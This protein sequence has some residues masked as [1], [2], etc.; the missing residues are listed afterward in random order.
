[1]ADKDL[2]FTGLTDQQAQ[3][4]HSVYLQGMWLFISVAIVAHLAVFIWRP[5]L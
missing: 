1:M 5:W 3:E 2:S 4:L